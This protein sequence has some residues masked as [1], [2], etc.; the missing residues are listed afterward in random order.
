[1]RETRTLA[2]LSEADCRAAIV[3]EARSWLGTPYHPEGRIKG[4]GTDCGML[5][6]EV[7]ERA[8]IVPHVAV[9]HYA[10]DWNKHQRS[11][12]YLNIILRYGRAIARE[13]M[14]PGDVAMWKFGLTRSHGAIVIAWP[15]VI[16]A[17]L[18]ERKVVL[19]DVA[20]DA[21]YNVQEPQFYSFW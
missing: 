14:K 18:R 15:N 16:H 19:C 13:Q 2:G 1:M 3:S 5:I 12:E 21:G 11:E 8:G 20:R 10:A 17:T 4:V 7:Y 6:A 9:P